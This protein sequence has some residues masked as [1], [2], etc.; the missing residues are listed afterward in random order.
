MTFNRMLVQSCHW[1]IL[2]ALIMV[3]T[4]ANAGEPIL[5]LQ[6]G[7][8]TNLVTC[9]SFSP[10]SQTLYAAGWDQ[11]VWV[12]N[13]NADGEF[14]LNTAASLRIPVGP[15]VAGTINSMALSRDGKW[16]AVGG[17]GVF[18]GQS[19][20]DDVG[21]MFA[22]S[23]MSREMRLDQGA[24]HVF[25][26]QT[27]E[28][29]VFRGHLGPIV[30]L[31][32]SPDPAPRLVSIAQ[33]W[34]QKKEGFVGGVRLWDIATRKRLQPSLLLPQ[35]TQTP[36]LAVRRSP[37]PSN[38]LL[39]SISTTDVDMNPDGTP[40][41][42]PQLRVWNA[43]RGT[44][45]KANDY[46]NTVFASGNQFL[47]GSFLPANQTGDFRGQLRFWDANGGAL[48][49][50]GRVPLTP[51]AGVE[52]LPNDVVGLGSNR[53][54]VA[55]LGIRRDPS[56]GNS[57]V[58][59]GAEL[60]LLT[61]GGSSAQ[62]QIALWPADP[63][64]T[65]KLTMAATP[66]GE[67]VAVAGSPNHDVLLY[68][69]SDLTG[70][71][72]TPQRLGLDV[73]RFQRASFVAQGDRTGILLEPR[74]DTDPQLV[75]D[76]SRRSVLSADTN[77]TDNTAPPTPQPQLVNNADGSRAVQITPP[78]PGAQPVQ[79]RLPKRHA[80]TAIA[81]VGLPAP[82]ADDA[83]QP[84]GLIAIASQDRGHPRLEL[85]TEKGI[86]FRHLVGHAHRIQSLTFSADGKWLL[87]TAEG[88]VVAMWNLS[89]WNRVIGKHGALPE[90]SVADSEVDGQQNV[91]APDAGGQL[92]AGDRILGRIDGGRMSPFASANDFYEFL[93][94][95]PVGSSATLQV[96]R[97]GNRV[98][99][100]TRIGQ[101]MDEAKPVFSLMVLPQGPG[102]NLTRW[103]A[104]SPL[105]PFD[106]SDRR[107]EEM[108][109]WHFNATE[110]EPSSFAPLKQYRSQYYR[111]HLVRD[112]LDDP[113]M[114]PPRKV[115]A[116]PAIHVSIP[117]SSADR[118]GAA[119]RLVHSLEA[120]VRVSIDPGFPM[121]DIAAVRIQSGDGEAQDLQ[122]QADG[123]WAIPL[124][125][126]AIGVGEHR[127]RATVS[128]TGQRGNN[129]AQDLLIRY[130]PLPPV[131]DLATKKPIATSAESHE[132]KATVKSETTGRTIVAQL[133]DGNGGLVDSWEGPSPL[134]VS[135][136]LPLA[137]DRNEFELVA[138]NSDAKGDDTPTSR[139]SLVVVRNVE[140]A[141]PHLAISEISYLDESSGNRIFQAWQPGN[142]IHVDA[143]EIRVHGHVEASK[144][145]SSAQVKPHGAVRAL[146]GFEPNKS[147][148]FEFNEQVQLRPGTQTFQLA[149]QAL[150]SAI[151]RT[152][153]EV[154]YRP[155]LPTA[156]IVAPASG[157]TITD[158]LV[159]GELDLDIQLED[160]SNKD[161]DYQLRVFVND[162]EQD[163]PDVIA[164]GGGGIARSKIK[165]QP[166]VNSVR[167]STTNEWQA[168]SST[169]LM[170]DYAPSPKIT[171]QS[172]A[173]SPESSAF[174]DML[175]EGDSSDE[176][177]SVFLA[178][179]ELVADDD[180][181]LSKGDSTFMLKLKQ[182]PL[183]L[184]GPGNKTNSVRLVTSSG[185]VVEVPVITDDDA[186]N[187]APERGAPPEVEI[188][189]PALVSV[190]DESQHPV[191][192]TVTSRQR[193][194]RV[195]VFHDNKML[196]HDR[197]VEQKQ[198]SQG[199]FIAEYSLTLALNTNFNEVRVLARNRHGEGFARLTVNRVIRPM[200]IVIEGFSDARSSRPTLKPMAGMGGQIRFEKPADKGELWLH[201]RV[202]WS[203]PKDPRLKTQAFRVHV[204]VNGFQQLPVVL[205]P[206][207]D[208]KSRE[209]VTQI[210]FGQQD[211]L[212]EIGVPNLQFQLEDSRRFYVDCAKPAK[213]RR[214][215][216]MVFSVDQGVTEKK[217]L[218]DAAIRALN[219]KRSPS[220]A[221]PQRRRRGATPLV[222]FTTPAFQEGFVYGPLTVGEVYRQR[223]MGEL[224]KVS[225]RVR[226][227]SQSDPGSD[228]IVIY[229]Q[230]AELLFGP[231]GFYL[232]TEPAN[233]PLTQKAVRNP[234]SLK[235]YSVTS[236]LLNGH[237]ETNP[238]AH[239][240]LLDV[241]RL[242]QPDEH[243]TGWPNDSRAAM[244]RYAW[245]GGSNSANQ[246][247]LLSGIERMIPDAGKL[248]QLTEALKS[249]D[250]AFRSEDSRTLVFD[251]FVPPALNEL[252][253]GGGDLP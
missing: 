122:F 240:L 50:A 91:V 39:V 208:G 123:S 172:T 195:D 111:R 174:A 164:Q 43:S 52:V 82:A 228:V 214:V 227:V 75:F 60:R 104:W 209:F 211:N 177:E 47:T 178:D 106:S 18:R 124:S 197:Q 198:D 166:G 53:Y 132:L 66:D 103:L 218:V 100:P 232:T 49:D 44:L 175:V 244:L 253:L 182:L 95:N 73:R 17:Q 110:T 33:E 108:L 243:L 119:N 59:V 252:Q 102:V 28:S 144:P 5:R 222:R 25:N 157:P 84:R 201:G 77:W 14:A 160:L 190:T 74:G 34:S 120:D 187:A 127:L 241:A 57:Y 2:P 188:A 153:I 24:I 149:A 147:P 239:V 203:D 64:T 86:P 23:A 215:H 76:V 207:R 85:F 145:L 70:D 26:T 69:T 115:S 199:R 152:E 226:A 134:I 6:G 219:G 118:Q 156:A 212:I 133:F 202:R 200:S 125:Q 37:A 13:K 116:P 246:R 217:T 151:T 46:A 31:A 98:Q 148:T 194:D 96:I 58:P 180:F 19:G 245:L 61:R 161:G 236:D 68:R 113:T 79:F 51:V 225:A 21:K 171:K 206:S 229:Y 54:I 27:R 231:D 101:G 20:F 154:V 41:G 63:T 1:A 9:L 22:T 139:A 45:Q 184:T 121:D 169:P 220:T 42:V 251:D 150:G 141:P 36:G 155:P 72:P 165:L 247:K 250:V 183:N 186:Q 29:F 97:N 176:I 233:S 105:G 114:I 238:G 179:R 78:L 210:V 136:S 221:T 193:I 38:S 89:D 196:I 67:F 170:L 83:S 137:E 242:P 162:I 30:S 205:Q 181:E 192:F 92:Q 55:G 8:P 12:W 99:V 4:F 224:Q 142:A 62:K 130:Q 135:K 248:E 10:D 146:A 168:V 131:I 35:V 88:H 235:Y 71:T 87:S 81:A 173:V 109:G 140:V 11:V 185:S 230:G 32:F 158:E 216:L 126:L 107:I 65:R 249:D 138:Q 191:R 94:R 90:S 167:V 204:W 117:G 189:G 93:W 15:G 40:V 128:T 213:K 3:G 112:L 16:L 129:F 159:G 234:E 56:R 163:I 80:L 7:G 223:V 143:A 237:V 48:S